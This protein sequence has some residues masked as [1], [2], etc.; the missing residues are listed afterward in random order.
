MAW[1]VDSAV[2]ANALADMGVD[3]IISN[4]LN[5]A[6]VLRSDEGV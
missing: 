6:E 2:T 1:P 3:G 4:A 5:I